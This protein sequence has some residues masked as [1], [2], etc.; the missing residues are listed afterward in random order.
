MKGFNLSEWAINHRPFV[1]FLMILFVAA[2]VLSYKQLGREEDPS[3]SIKTMIVQ[4]Y[5]P[6]A[7]LLPEERNQAR[8]FDNLRQ[9][10]R[11]HGEG[12]DPGRLVSSSQEDR[13]HKVN[14]AAGR[15][16]AEFQRRVWRC[17]RHHLR[18]HGRRVHA[19]RAA[20]LCRTN[21]HADIDDQECGEGAADRC[22]G[23][24]ILPRIRHSSI[25]R[26]GCQSR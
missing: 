25:G 5:W 11:Q 9:R 23:P 6:G 7:T 8:R 22:S 20:R 1:W 3:F 18:I 14:T 17:F 13:R 26:T 21:S 16:R 12:G 4:T 15:P 2:G 19:P 24:E 10:P